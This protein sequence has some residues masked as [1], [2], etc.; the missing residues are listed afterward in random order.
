[1]LI[2]PTACMLSSPYAP[3]APKA[4]SNPPASQ[5]AQRRST[6]GTEPRQLDGPPLALL[7]SWWSAQMQARLYS[8]MGWSRGRRQSCSIHVSPQ[9]SSA[10]AFA[11]ANASGKIGRDPSMGVGVNVTHDSMRGSTWAGIVSAKGSNY[12]ASQNPRQGTLASEARR[13][14]MQSIEAASVAMVVGS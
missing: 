11:Y 1:M 2:A 3:Q 12:P 5:P 9:N 14:L 7:L 8:C 10:S 6:T 4:Q 13:S